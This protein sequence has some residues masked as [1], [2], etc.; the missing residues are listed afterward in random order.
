M[1][2]AHR[3]RPRLVFEGV[4]QHRFDALY[5][6]VKGLV[7]AGA[8]GTLLTAA[9]Q[10]RCRRTAEYYRADAWRGTWAREGGAVLINQAIHFIDLLVWLM[11]GVR[12][13]CGTYTNLTHRRVI[14]T[15]DTA[16]GALRF[17]NGAVGT[18]EA[19][20][21]SHL[22]WEPTLSF[23]GSEGSLDLRGNQPLKVAFA[24]PRLE[25]KIRAG[26]AAA[27]KEPGKLFGKSYY[28]TGHPAQIADFVAA[29]RNRRRPT[30]P[31][32]SARHTVDVV[33]A[34]YESHRTGRWMP[35]AGRP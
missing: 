30:I 4:F 35:V 12:A 15:E 33:L 7:Q 5:R 28:G 31:A 14:E 21:S 26:L 3:R 11:G 34:L 16:A 25:K 27:L 19:T 8:F 6:Y 10:V 2:A 29:I 23:H 20:C 9:V 1:L 18:L 13:V 32:A 17:R 24:D 22:G